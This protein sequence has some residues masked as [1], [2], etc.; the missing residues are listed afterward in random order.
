MD[1]TYIGADGQEH[2]LSTRIE[3]RL[4]NKL[5]LV[6]LQVSGYQPKMFRSEALQPSDITN[7]YSELMALD[8]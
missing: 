1:L 7:L 2:H 6:S 3:T 5:P 4:L 8:L